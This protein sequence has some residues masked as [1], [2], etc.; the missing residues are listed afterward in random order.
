MDQRSR[1]HNKVSYDMILYVV[2]YERI[3]YEYFCLFVC[4]GSR[5]QPNPVRTS[6]GPGSDF[7]RGDGP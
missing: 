5:H 6:A 7:P 1:Y 3:I 4:F 2:Q